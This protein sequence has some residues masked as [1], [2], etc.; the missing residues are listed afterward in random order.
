MKKV[1]IWWIVILFS[2]GKTQAWM[3]TSDY[4]TGEEYKNYLQSNIEKIENN[5]VESK[6]NNN[7]LDG[8][9]KELELLNQP[10]T[11]EDTIIAKKAISI[12]KDGEVMYD[13]RLFNTD[14]SQEPFSSALLWWYN[15]TQA[16]NYAYN[17]VG[18]RNSNY[19]FYSWM[20]NCTNFVSQILEAW[21]ISYIVNAPLWKY[22]KKNWYY[23]N[24]PNAVPSWTW[25]WANNLKNHMAVKTDRYESVALYSSL[26]IGD[27]IQADWD[28]NG[29]AD[30]SMVITKKTWNSAWN[31]YLTYSSSY[32]TTSTDKKD[33]KLSDI[34][35]GNPWSVYYFWKVV[36]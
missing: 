12:N 26:S 11:K 7:I 34:V 17:W 36:Y 31:I 3:P 2:F 32:N 8:Y 33:R 9:K 27:I 16:V 21:Y 4:K 22:D 1:L 13:K 10:I 28:N 35:S 20:W 25:W 23:V 29:T 14:I 5:G 15:R 19:D 18:K 24:T 30:H 6:A